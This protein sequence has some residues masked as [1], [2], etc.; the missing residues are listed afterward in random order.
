MAY[1]K[2]VYPKKSVAVYSK[3]VQ[4]S[5]LKVV[6]PKKVKRLILKNDVVY[7]KVVY[8]KKKVKRSI[9]KK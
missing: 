9:L 4:W 7:S 5:I 8:P 1:S 6:D 2:V 3:K